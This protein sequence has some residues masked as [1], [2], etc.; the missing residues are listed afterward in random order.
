MLSCKDV[1]QKISQAQ[2]RTLTRREHIGVNLHLL[3][4][5]AC[6]RFVKQLT[7]LTA[8]ARRALPENAT[9]GLDDKSLPEAARQRIRKRLE[10]GAE[11]PG[12]PE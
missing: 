3:I 6:R 7:I 1:T 4:C 8:A 12:T 10:H 2:D 9:P 5:Y 11:K